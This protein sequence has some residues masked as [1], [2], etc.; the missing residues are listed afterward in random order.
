MSCKPIIG[1]TTRVKV[2][3]RI[4]SINRVADCEGKQASLS[5]GKLHL[6]VKNPVAAIVLMD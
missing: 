6:R 5:V 1:V 4:F 3:V 2:I